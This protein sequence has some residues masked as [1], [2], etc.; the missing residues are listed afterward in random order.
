MQ[1]QGH[2]PVDPRH[3][4][5]VR[6]YPG[7]DGDPGLVL[8]VALGVTEIGDNR[9]HRGCTGT[10]QGVDPEEQLHEIVI[11]REPGPLDQ[12]GVPPP[13]VLEDAYEQVPLRK[14]QCLVGAQG[15]PEV[16]GDQTRPISCSPS[17]QTAR[18]HPQAPAKTTATTCLTGRGAGPSPEDKDVPGGEGVSEAQM[19]LF[20]D[21]G[22]RDPAAAPDWRLPAKSSRLETRAPCRNRT[23]DTSLTMAV[24]CRLS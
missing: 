15:A 8:L 22:L 20:P 3:L 24:L 23:D 6:A 16:G 9:R 17:R 4:D 12:E 5:S 1:V 19:T 13:H 14:P 2:N 7:P 10:L 21:P 18:N 11:G